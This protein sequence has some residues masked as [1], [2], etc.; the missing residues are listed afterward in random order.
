ML[1]V[2]NFDLMRS[3][4]RRAVHFSGDRRVARTRDAIHAGPYEK[5]RVFLFR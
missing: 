5:M 1:R 3:L 4:N 2:Q